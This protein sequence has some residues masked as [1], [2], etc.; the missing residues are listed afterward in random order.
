MYP[1]KVQNSFTV[2]NFSG[3]LMSKINAFRGVKKILHPSTFRALFCTSALFIVQHNRPT[4]P[5]L[6][7]PHISGIVSGNFNHESQIKT[8][9]TPTVSSANFKTSDSY[10]WVPGSP[11]FDS[12]V[13]SEMFFEINLGLSQNVPGYS[14]VIGYSQFLQVW[15]LRK[16][17]HPTAL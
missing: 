11:K 12:T 13:Y 8:A 14:S 10:Q 5:T 16:L 1:K 9:R 15:K 17:I 2:F 4:A 6:V 3:S 7:T